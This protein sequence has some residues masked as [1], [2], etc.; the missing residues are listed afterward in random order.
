MVAGMAVSVADDGHVRGGWLRA[1]V[2]GGTAG[3]DS[4]SP[5]CFTFEDTVSGDNLCLCV[6]ADNQGSLL[7]GDC[8]SGTNAY[9]GLGSAA[10]GWGTLQAG[11]IGLRSGGSGIAT[12]QVQVVAF[13]VNSDYDVSFSDGSIVGWTSGNSPP[14]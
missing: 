5:G 7:Q 9:L 4:P 13:K 12:L 2:G 6:N 8:S 1:P 3:I 10:G 11:T 14:V